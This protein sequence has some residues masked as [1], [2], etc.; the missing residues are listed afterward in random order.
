MAHVGADQRM[1]DGEGTKLEQPAAQRDD[2]DK[3]ADAEAVEET[4]K[5]PLA[6]PIGAPSKAAK[7]AGGGNDGK[8]ACAKCG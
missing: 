6:S 1:S 3:N 8:N 4:R 2:T 5:R 7:T